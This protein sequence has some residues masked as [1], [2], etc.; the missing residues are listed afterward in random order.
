MNDMPLHM[1]NKKYHKYWQDRNTKILKERIYYNVNDNSTKE[2][3]ELH[4]SSQQ[5]TFKLWLEDFITY[6][7]KKKKNSTGL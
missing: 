7:I 4:D 5:P 6:N 2:I 3:F 1:Y